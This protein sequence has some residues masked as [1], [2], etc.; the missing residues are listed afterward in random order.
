MRLARL[1]S[2]L[3]ACAA[4]ALIV[5][6]CGKKEGN[7]EPKREGL[8]LEVGGLK[9]RVYITRQINQH[10]AEDRSYY[11]GPEAPPGTTYYGVFL[12]ACNEGDQPL[13]PVD[14]FT[15][16]DNQGN[17][18]KPLELPETNDFAYRP[19]RLVKGACVPEAGSAPANGPTGGALLVFKIPVQSIENRPLELEI[20]DVNDKGKLEKGEIE[21][22]L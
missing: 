6:G 5:S 14:D 4:A 7:A 1:L 15:V 8:G 11:D 9:Y 17:E 13:K 10:D 20:E 2:V 12:T 16:R 3:A 22:D 21:L 18:F 19:R